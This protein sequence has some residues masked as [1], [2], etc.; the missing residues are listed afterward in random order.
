[1][2]EQPKLVNQIP[3]ESSDKLISEQK[4]DQAEVDIFDTK[5]VEK[6]TEMVN[7]FF[8][9]GEYYAAGEAAAA[10][11][12]TGSLKKAIQG[13]LSIKA[14]HKADKLISF[15][16]GKDREL[17]EQELAKLDHELEEKLNDHISQMNR[18]YEDDGM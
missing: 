5:A 6:L 4:V 9:V 11:G 8:E 16:D 18:I 13:C 1:M 2:L 17:A 10:I 14:R 3:S 12:D 15:L 7:N